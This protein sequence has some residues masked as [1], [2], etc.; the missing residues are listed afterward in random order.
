MT[1]PMRSA[2]LT[3]HPVTT[4]P[5]FK[6]NLP[7]TKRRCSKYNSQSHSG[8]GRGG[9]RKAT[10]N[11]RQPRQGVVR[12]ARPLP[13]DPAGIPQAQADIAALTAEHNKLEPAR[14]L[15]RNSRPRM[16]QCRTDSPASKTSVSSAS[17][18][19]IF[20]DRIQ[21]E[22]QLATVY[23]KWSAQVLL[24]HRIVLHL[25]LQSWR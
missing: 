8:P 25:I 15:S 4:A 9:L 2:I 19:S 22:Q 13:V 20:D 14:R 11:A 17:L 23:G 3:A 16:G 12:S 1:W 7:R 21:T 6:V 24:Q 18:L 10:R 5:R